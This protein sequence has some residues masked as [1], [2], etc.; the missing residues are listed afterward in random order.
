MKKVMKKLWTLALLTMVS[1]MASAE[2]VI[3]VNDSYPGG[4]VSTTQDEPAADGSVVV[5]ITVTPDDG[6]YIDKSDILVVPTIPISGTRDGEP[7]FDVKFD[8]A[9]IEGED[10]SDPT[11]AQSYTFTVPE[12]QG[13]WVK[14][15]TFHEVIVIDN[16]IGKDDGSKGGSDNVTWEY[17]KDKNALLINGTGATRDFTADD[18]PWASDLENI[19]SVVIDKGVTGLGD[20]I[21]AGCKNLTIITIANTNQV[22]VLGKDAIPANEGL[23]IDVP[24]NLYN[25]YLTTEGWDKL[26]IVSTTGVA[27]TGVTFGDNNSYD[28]FVSDNDV[29]IPSVLYAYVISNISEKGLELTEVKGAIPAN[30]PVLLFSEKLKGD[31]FKTANTK[32]DVTVGTNLLNVVTDEDGLTV[33]LGEVWMLYNDVFYYTQAG[34]IPKGGVYLANSSNASKTRSSYPLGSRGDTTGIVSL[35]TDGTLGL[36]SNSAWY[37]LDGRKYTTMPTRKGIYIKDGKK[38]IIK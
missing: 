37:S 9:E 8:L 11:Q 19:T 32:T 27:M 15:A 2:V 25:E 24:G 12:G 23:E 34:T 5:T 36:S 17:D 10:Y 13:A 35:R 29:M 18:L 21:F 6:Y 14:E 38:I 22:L 16:N 33:S 26:A 1:T 31:D 4:K 28:T 30:T 7:G 3:D 20:N